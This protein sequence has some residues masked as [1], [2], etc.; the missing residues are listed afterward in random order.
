MATSLPR[1]VFPGESVSSLLLSAA[2]AGATVRLGAGLHLLPARGAAP[3]GAADGAEEADAE[4]GDVV[5]TRVGLLAARAGGGGGG[6]VRVSVL[7]GGGAGGRYVAAVGDAVVGVVTERGAEAY[8]LSLRGGVGAALPVLAFDGA[9]KRIKPS[10]A[11]GALVFARVAGVDRHCDVEL[12]CA[13]AGGAGGAAPRRDWM[14]GAALYGELA[15]GML[16][17]V[18]LAH[19]RRLLRPD[20]ALLATLGAS[21]AFEVAVGVNGLVYVRAAAPRTAVIICN[22]IERSERLTEEE[23]AEFARRLATAAADA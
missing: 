21:L 2:P 23:C 19:A 20:C 3:G 12:S 18:S 17:S 22:A 9:S 14:T 8:R 6:A 1:L 5:A 15:G 11:P 16:V 10:L 7:S 4:D 13:S